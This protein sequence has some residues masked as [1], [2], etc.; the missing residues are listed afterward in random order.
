MSRS[1]RKLR[2]SVEEREGEVVV[3]LEGELE[4]TTRRDWDR[5]ARHPALQ[6]APSILLHLDG[7]ERLGGRGVAALE[8]LTERWDRDGTPYRIQLKDPRLRRILVSFDK[9][10]PKLLKAPKR[11]GGVGGKLE[12]AALFGHVLRVS[13]ISA[14]MQ[15]VRLDRRRLQQS[16]RDMSATGL[17]AV[18]LVATLSFLIGGVLAFQG[19]PTLMRFGQE[20][21]IADIVGLSVVREIG[22]LITAILV[23][24]RSGAALTAEI[25][26]MKVSEE[27]DALR[28]MGLGPIDVLVAP[29]LRALFLVLPVLTAI[30]DFLGVVGGLIVGR[31]VLD[32]ST[33]AYVDRSLEA[34]SIMDVAAGL[35]KALCFAAVICSVCAWQGFGCRNGASGVGRA[36][37]RAVVLSIVGIIVVDAIATI[38]LFSSRT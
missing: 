18:P 34:I 31:A 38:I 2:V 33:Q 36:T 17:S 22:P 10:I 23:A 37:T 1:N 26:T 29:R 6:A 21:F 28:V 25:G 8:D 19:A 4:D 20:R 16:L 9:L 7:L 3:G 35:I 15:I 30:A 14:I 11:G 32:L 5:L 27:I 13:L 12:Q 24:G